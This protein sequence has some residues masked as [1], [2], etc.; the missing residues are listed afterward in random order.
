MA[1]LLQLETAENLARLRPPQP[2]HFHALSGDMAG[3][4]SCSLN[5]NY[6]LIFSAANVPAPVL[7]LGGPDWARITQI[8]IHGVVDYHEHNK[9]QPV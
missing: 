3:L 9:K 1:R 4:Y 5:G 2:G 8:R 6:R 7:D